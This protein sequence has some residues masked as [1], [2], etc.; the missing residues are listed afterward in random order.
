MTTPTTTPHNPNSA[1]GVPPS[2]FP[3][4]SP[5]SRGGK[6]S[7]KRSAI[8]AKALGN[9]VSGQSVAN[10]EV[11]FEGFAAKGI[12]MEDVLPRENVF[13]FHAWRALG[14]VVRRGEHGVQ[15][16]TIIP[17]TKKDP[18]TGEEIPVRKVKTTTVFHI[19]Q[20]ELLTT[21]YQA[22][23][24]D[25][26]NHDLGDA[27]PGSR[28]ADPEQALGHH[29]DDGRG[30]RAGSASSQASHPSPLGFPG[31][32][33]RCVPAL[34]LRGNQ[35][36]QGDHEPANAGTAKALNSYE[37][38]QA[39]RKERFEERAVKARA[40]STSIYQH[41]RS[42]G[43]AIPFGQPILVGHHSERR[44]RN[45][46]ARITKTYEAAFALD[47]KA[48]HYAAKAAGVGKG[49]VSSDDPDA[50][51]KLQRQL[52]E[53]EAAQE[54][55]TAANKAIRVH[56]KDGEAAQIAALASLGIARTAAISLLQDGRAFPS[57]ALQNN[58][59]NARRIRL[60][61]AELESRRA[62]VPVEVEGEGYTYKEDP[63]ENRVMFCFAGKPAAEVRDVLKR[64][65]FRWSPTRDA[66]VRQLN[67][68][69]RWAGQEVRKALDSK[70]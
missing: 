20:T 6:T 43:E 35:E 57:Y 5:T 64:H 27:A 41:A 50:V 15:V 17:C 68:A 62:A 24:S 16:V 47:D 55:M 10:Y 11:I 23:Q 45:Y 28:P 25:E 67:N 32:G 14:R 26:R 48:Q 56:K 2:D 12:P 49:G 36:G 13:T 51:E 19:S 21:Y 40:K 38:K 9:A 69:A 66:W 60:R 63:E 53:V 70:R 8:E 37:A 65:A 1:E 61:I 39:A 42:M 59:A 22:R 33:G 7:A 44:D 54:R 18:L 58:N 34:D 46:R 4:G 29:Q 3:Q 30:S 52:A 31:A